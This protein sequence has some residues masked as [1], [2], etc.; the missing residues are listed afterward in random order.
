MS[1]GMRERLT[2]NSSLRVQPPALTEFDNTDAVPVTSARALMQIQPNALHKDIIMISLLKGW[3]EANGKNASKSQRLYKRMF[4]KLKELKLISP[5]SVEAIKQCK[6]SYNVLLQTLIS[7]SL[8]SSSEDAIDG[9]HAKA[10]VPFPFGQL[11]PSPDRDDSSFFSRRY[12]TDFDQKEHIG[13]G[14]FGK[15]YEVRNKL[16]KS[17]YAIK[18]IK[19]TQKKSNFQCM[20]REI[21]MLAKLHHPNVVRYHQS[22]FGEEVHKRSRKNQLLALKFNNGDQRSN[23]GW[24]GEEMDSQ[25]EEDDEE[26]EEEG[27]DADKGVQQDIEDQSYSGIGIFENSKKKSQ[28]I[29]GCTVPGASPIITEMTECEIKNE[30]HTKHSSEQVTFSIGASEMNLFEEGERVDSTEIVVREF[31]MQTSENMEEGIKT[32]SSSHVKSEIKTSSVMKHNRISTAPKEIPVMSSSQ[33]QSNKELA[34]SHTESESSSGT[35]IF[36]NNEAE[37]SDEEDFMLPSL[38]EGL[39]GRAPKKSKNVRHGND[40]GLSVRDEM[41][42]RG[43]KVVDEY[44]EEIDTT[45]KKTNTFVR[46]K[47]AL[48]G[49][50]GGIPATTVAMLST[51]SGTVMNTATTHC[52]SRTH[53]V[54]SQQS[55]NHAV[56]PRT[57]R[58]ISWDGQESS[59]EMSSGF[60][61]G[62]LHYKRC[63]YLYIQMELCS[64]TLRRWMDDRNNKIRDGEN[65]FDV[66]NKEHNQNIIRQ[67]LEGMDYIHNQGIL[68]RDVTPK[69]VF[70]SGEEDS[71]LHVK[72]GDFGLAREDSVNEPKTPL[73]RNPQSRV[74]PEC[75]FT[76]CNSEC[77]TTGL[78]TTTYAAPEQLHGTMYD[79]KSDM[80]SVGLM[81]F[82][83][84]HPFVTGMERSESLKALREGSI[85]AEIQ[86]RW[87]AQYSTIKR[88]TRHS[89]D[90]RPSARDILHG[91]MFPS[92]D[93]IISN[94]AKK[95]SSLAKENS[96]QANEIE[97]LRALLAARDTEVQQLKVG[98]SRNHIK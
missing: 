26:E 87:P 25:D 24:Y 82:E 60:W 71:K 53:Y 96:S 80:Y 63:C 72:I 46:K 89:S 32:L 8:S 95:I 37:Q 42:G 43:S 12:E 69:N 79:N 92:K 20:Q 51:R 39:S 78:G 55:L 83:L 50:K 49:T 64:S 33:M 22:W 31:F 91:E 17:H 29:Q 76:S 67:I 18:K 93:E 38:R 90:E 57:Q 1:K 61:P 36:R 54:S 88:L 47:S 74:S 84:F 44:Y 94:Q 45:T 23:Q 98:A 5:A 3:C 40:V 9:S 34:M 48:N 68:H 27:D 2:N 62:S 52:R 66:V 13:E 56:R 19:V 75:S 21:Q 81:L 77:F 73:R 86:Q 14:G 28:S 11:L 35:I 70:L 30:I 6:P 97:R 65:Q 10:V 4:G 58:S 7:L 16:D 15:V 85:P 41:N 59:P